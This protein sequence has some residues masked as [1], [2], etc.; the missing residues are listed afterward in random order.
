MRILVV[1]KN[2]MWSAR[3]A[4]SIRHLGHEAVVVE[5]LPAELGFDVAIVN[6][7]DGDSAVGALQASGIKVIAHAGHKEKE[8]LEVGRV[9]G[10]DL[11][12]TNSELTYKLQDL[13]ERLE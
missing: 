4:N 3:L 6:L 5:T 10:C 7:A 11:V 2:L 9:A 8:R 13:L 12:V 1:E